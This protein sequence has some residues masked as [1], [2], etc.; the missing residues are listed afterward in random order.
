LDSLESDL[1]INRES[2]VPAAYK[3]KQKLLKKQH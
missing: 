1:L 2:E 3:I